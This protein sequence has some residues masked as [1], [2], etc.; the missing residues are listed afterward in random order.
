MFFIGHSAQVKKEAT[1][2]METIMTAM[3]VIPDTEMTTLDTNVTALGR[4]IEA[5]LVETH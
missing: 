1:T 2:T 3:A 5:T 4:E